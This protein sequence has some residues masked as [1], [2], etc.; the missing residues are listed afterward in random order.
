MS[1][2]ISYAEVCGVFEDPDTRMKLHDLAQA[3]KVSREVF[4]FIKEVLG[5]VAQEA[6]ARGAEEALQEDED[7]E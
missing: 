6:Y 4:D 1:D 5:P 7:D 3:G 2:S